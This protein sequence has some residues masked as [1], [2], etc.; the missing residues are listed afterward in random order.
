MDTTVIQMR[1]DRLMAAMVA[2]GMQRPDATY[3]LQS[4]RPEPTFWV[5]YAIPDPR[6][7]S[8]SDRK[9]LFFEQKDGDLFDQADAWVAAQ[10]DAEERKVREF[11]RA[12]GG[13]IDLGRENGIEVDYLNPLMETAKRLSENALTHQPQLQEESF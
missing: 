9:T 3:F 2:K 12:L 4:G 1:L 10:P 5:E 8:G 11:Q 7:H 6:R 13:L